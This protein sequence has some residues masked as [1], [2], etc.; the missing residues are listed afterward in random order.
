M[1]KGICMRSSKLLRRFGSREGHFRPSPAGFT[2]VELLVVIAIIGI[3]IALLLPAVQAAREAAR[4][5]QCQNNLKQIGLAVLNYVDTSRGA[6]PAGL[7]WNAPTTGGCCGFAWSATVLPFIEAYN[8]YEQVDFNYGSNYEV[9]NVAIDQILPFY[10]CPSAPPGQLVSLSSRPGG[11]DSGETNYG[12]VATMWDT[13]EALALANREK[14]TGI[15]FDMY[16]SEPRILLEQ[17]ADGTSKT[18][19]VAECDYDETGD[20]WIAAH[21]PTPVCFIGK[22]WAHVNALTTAWGINSWLPRW[23]APIQSHHP[24]GAQVVFA[25]GHVKFLNE[26]IDQVT[27]DRL[28]MKADGEVLDQ[29]DY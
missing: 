5:I 17:V 21:C 14:G 8:E 7:D 15:M 18:M 13:M 27:F 6:F 1:R 23:D 16:D 11:F 3:L 2:L 29:T 22:D 25:D 26:M 9:N 28:G 10:H 24:G 12:N 19:M 4:R 20:P